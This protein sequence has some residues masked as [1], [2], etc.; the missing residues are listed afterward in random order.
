MTTLVLVFRIVEPATQQTLFNALIAK[1]DAMPVILLEDVPNG[2]LL[3][4]PL[5]LLIAS[6]A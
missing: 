5:V 1:V 6:S 4:Q 2:Q 3:Y